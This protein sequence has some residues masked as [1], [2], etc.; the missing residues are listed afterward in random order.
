MTTEEYVIA[1]KRAEKLIELDP[2]PA[3]I[4]GKELNSLVKLIE[5]Y[6]TRL[7]PIT[8]VLPDLYE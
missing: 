4:K 8:R 5:E 6:E 7:Y 3:T 1:L 2:D